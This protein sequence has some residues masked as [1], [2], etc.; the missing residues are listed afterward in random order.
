MRALTICFLITSAIVS[1]QATASTFR[2]DFAGTFGNGCFGD[3]SVP[4]GSELK[5]LIGTEFSGYFLFPDTGTDV[6]DTEP[7][8]GIFDFGAGQSSFFFDSEVD[9]FD[10]YTA[11]VRVL[12]S[13]CADFS[14]RGAIAQDFV[15]IQSVV[16]EYF[17]ALVLNG[18]SADPENT[19]IG[20]DIPTLE[21][22]TSLAAPIPVFPSSNPGFAI[23]TTDIGGGVDTVTFPLGDPMQATVTTVPLPSPVWL[24]A[25]ALGYLGWI[26][27]LRD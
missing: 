22:L 11:D 4:P 26:G 14:C 25:T 18:D 3:C 27:R 15:S 5:S 19:L 24:F 20:D 7:Q 17:F 16:G 6:L 23:Y 2:I 21:E 12:V 13:D 9:S 8:R 10:T 1:S